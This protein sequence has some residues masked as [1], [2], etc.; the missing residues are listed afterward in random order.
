M[1]S[2]NLHIDAADARQVGSSA[3]NS[4]PSVCPPRETSAAWVGSPAA[5]SEASTP[6]AAAATTARFCESPTKLS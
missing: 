2:R 4:Q 3:A 5:C 1:P 6:A